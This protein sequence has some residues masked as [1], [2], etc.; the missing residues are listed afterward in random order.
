MNDKDAM[1]LLGLVLADQLPLFFP[2]EWSARLVAEALHRSTLVKM[3][4]EESPC[5]RWSIA[6][7]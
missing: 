2:D 5:G 6:H 7:P 3:K 1:I 4:V